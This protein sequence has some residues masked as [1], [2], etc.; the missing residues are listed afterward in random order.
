[1]PQVEVTF[2]I[3]A[4]GILHVT[5][6]DK[7]TG[8][9][10]K[11]TVTAS[12]NLNKQDIDKMVQ[13][14]RGQ[15]AEDRKRKELIDARNSADSLAYQTEKAWGGQ[16]VPEAERASIESKISELR[17]FPR[18]DGPSEATEELQNIWHALSQQLCSQESRNQAVVQPP[19]R[20]ES[21]ESDGDVIEGE[22][23]E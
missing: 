18:G 10:Q 17:R 19:R 22:V 5:A 11:I 1:M 16:P 6:R 23:K 15:E 13:E 14:A 8:K 3:D 20:P 2:D 21:G 12:T 4:N 9:E 7:A